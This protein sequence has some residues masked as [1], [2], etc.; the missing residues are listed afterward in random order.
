MLAVASIMSPRGQAAFGLTGFS[1]PAMGR[2]A[3]ATTAVSGSRITTDQVSSA[4]ETCS[5]WFLAAGSADERAADLAS[6]GT[7]A[8]VRA[9]PMASS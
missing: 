5:T 4:E 1:S 9:P 8:A 6:T 7:M 3:T 2:A